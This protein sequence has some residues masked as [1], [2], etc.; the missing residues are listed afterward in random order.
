MDA[1]ESTPP[2]RVFLADYAAPVRDRLTSLFETILGVE[3][4]G[5]AEDAP[6]A[7]AGILETGADV[8]VIELRLTGGSGLELISALTRAAPKVVKIVLTNLSGPAFRAACSDAGADF[9]F[10]KTADV[11]AACRTVRTLASARRPHAA[12]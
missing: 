4:V 5:E 8:A 1:R 3:V 11:D 10:D 12:E 6:A 7:L 2:L 9:F